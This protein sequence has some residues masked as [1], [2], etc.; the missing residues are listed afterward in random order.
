MQNS[1]ASPT[2]T[3]IVPGGH[4]PPVSWPSE[5]VFIEV[6]DQGYLNSAASPVFASIAPGGHDPPV[7]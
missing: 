5:S 4:D 3:I 1:A 6:C 2:F 7:S